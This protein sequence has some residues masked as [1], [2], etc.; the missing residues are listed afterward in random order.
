VGRE[1]D[2]VSLNVFS[3][4]LAGSAISIM[5]APALYRVAAPL[6]D[7]A[8]ARNPD[9]AIGTFLAP[10]DD[11]HPDLRGHAVIC[12]FGDV[13]HLI[14]GVLDRYDFRYVVIDEDIRTARRA[15]AEGIPAVIGNASVPAVLEHANPGRARVLVLAMP[16][17]VATRIVVDYVKIH[18]PRLDVVAR[19]HSEEERRDL[20]QRGVNM[21]LLGE[22]ELALEMTRHTLHR[23]GVEALVTGQVIHRMRNQ[24]E[25]GDELWEDAVPE[26]ERGSLGLEL[27]RRLRETRNEDDIATKPA[28]PLA[29]IDAPRPV[30]K[31]RIKDV[32]S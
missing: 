29:E 10:V 9:P 13:G 19:T 23:F 31:P 8:V 18:H 3:L 17:P 24:L 26:R 20:I 16:D 12:G 22:W 15:V 5:L 1:D 32:R 7:W 6:A 2:A 14:A 21:V 30:R 25:V 11:P 28:E 4:M 27:R